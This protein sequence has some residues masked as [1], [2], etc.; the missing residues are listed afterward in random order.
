MDLMSLPDGRKLVLEGEH[1]SREDVVYITNKLI[2][3]FGLGLELNV[4]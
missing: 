2:K 3:M 1:L 4:R